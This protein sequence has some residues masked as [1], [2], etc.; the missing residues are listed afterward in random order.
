MAGPC[1]DIQRAN[2]PNKSMLLPAVSSDHARKLMLIP[3][4]YQEE[5]Q[6]NKRM[7]LPAVKSDHAKKLM[8]IPA[9]NQE[10]TWKRKLLP[11][12]DYKQT[13]S[14]LPNSGKSAAAIKDKEKIRRP[15][16]AFIIFANEWRRNIAAQNPGEKSKQISTR[17]GAMWKSLRYDEREQYM[18][19]ARKLDAEHKKKYPDYVYCPKVA[20]VQK[21]L[22]EEARNLKRRIVKSHKM[23]TAPPDTGISHKASKQVHVKVFYGTVSPRMKEL[24]AISQNLGHQGCV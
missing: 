5:T 20:R 13:C 3:A 15:P 22:R 23:N 12:E 17:L 24:P 7:L 4:E 2:P 19:M 18:A 14:T 9:E 10:E 8:L 21:A 6:R 16:N 11:A 1:A